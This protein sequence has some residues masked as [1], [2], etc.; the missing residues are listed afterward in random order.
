MSFTVC[1]Q[2]D[3]PM[4]GKNIR[5]KLQ[6]SPG[7]EDSS[8]E[9]DGNRSMGAE[10]GF[11]EMDS[12]RRVRRS[13]ADDLNDAGSSPMD[14]TREDAESWDEER[15]GSLSPLKSSIFMMRSP[16]PR[17]SAR[18][19]CRFDDRHNYGPPVA[20]RPDTPPHKTFRKLRLFDTPH[21]PKVTGALQ[22]RIVLLGIF[23]C[24]TKMLSSC[25]L[26]PFSDCSKFQ[27]AVRYSC[28]KCSLV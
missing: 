24:A 14:G 26:C 6:F 19:Y 16:S 28:I 7:D 13:S 20:D 8:V 22:I 12:P 25:I 17:K 5:Q 1:R 2:F 10:S 15:F 18:S 9:E 4:A 23:Q 11:T 21:T 27:N 3:S